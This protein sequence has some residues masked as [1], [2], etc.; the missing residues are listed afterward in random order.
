MKKTKNKITN[1]KNEKTKTTPT[2][3]GRLKETTVSTGGSCLPAYRHYCNPTAF[4]CEGRS[5]LPVEMVLGYYRHFKR[6]QESNRR[7]KRWFK[8]ISTNVQS[9]YLFS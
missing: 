8:A 5:L 9:D 7:F 1:N 2:A 6:Q 3:G 4:G